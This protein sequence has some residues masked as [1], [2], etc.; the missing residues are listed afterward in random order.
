MAPNFVGFES[1]L[2]SPPNISGYAAHRETGVCGP[3][4]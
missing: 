3:V 4:K 1:Y 2:I